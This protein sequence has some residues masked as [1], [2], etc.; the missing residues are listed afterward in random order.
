MFFR[1]VHE[2]QQIVAHATNPAIVEAAQ[3]ELQYRLTRK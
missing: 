1:T 2:L 3:C